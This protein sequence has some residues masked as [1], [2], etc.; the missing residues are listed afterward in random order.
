VRTG[1]AAFSYQVLATQ[2]V[3]RGYKSIEGRLTRIRDGQVVPIR[4]EA[5]L[6]TLLGLPC[7]HGQDLLA[8]RQS[9]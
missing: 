6:F 5:D 1:S 2:W 3:R 7:K 4:E 9:W 8:H